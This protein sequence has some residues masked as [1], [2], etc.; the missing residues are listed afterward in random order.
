MSNL[1]SLPSLNQQSNCSNFSNNNF[2]LHH[3]S[4]LKDDNCYNSGENKQNNHVNDYM[5]SNFS[6]C[7]CKLDDVLNVSTNNRGIT[8]KDGYGVSECNV[9]TDTALRISGFER[10]YKS[11]LQLFPR[12]FMTTPFLQKGE[13]KPDL[14]S[15]LISSLQT[16][17]HKQMQNVSEDNIYTPLTENL[18]RNVQ[19]T[20]HIVQEDVNKRWVRGG[21]PSRQSVRDIDYLNRSKDSDVVKNLLRQKKQYL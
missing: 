19:D 2:V 14:E 3:Q 9:D 11:D 8:V 1:R 5:L 13:V 17:K 21:I 4:K 20:D 15:K 12:P 6:S 16:V 18:L 10:H 7:D